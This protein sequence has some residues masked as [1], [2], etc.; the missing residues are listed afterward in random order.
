MRKKI[1]LLIGVLFL[2]SLPLILAANSVT[3]DSP[4]ANEEMVGAFILNAS[5]DTNT[6]RLENAT[7]YY[8]VTGGSW[9]LIA[10]VSN[11]TDTDFN[12]TWD[13]T[14][15]VDALNMIIAVNV[16][17]ST[18]TFNTSD[19]STGVDIDNGVPTATHSSI[20][21]ADSGKVTIDADFTLGIDADSTIGIQN[22]TFWVGSN[23]LDVTATSNACS[24]SVTTGNFSITAAGYYNYTITA[25]DANG[26]ETNTSSRRIEIVPLGGGGGKQTTVQTTTE[27]PVVT[28]TTVDTPS[29]GFFSRTIGTIGS[30]ISNFFSSI[31]NFFKNLFS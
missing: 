4:A 13:T 27:E 20:S 29:E 3:L 14:G 22:C 10:E 6:E 25:R 11:Y 9:T 18:H 15:I 31:G 7:F 23:S 2:F 12:Y 1:G 28:D 19:T 8:K 30:S 21:L 17:N 5:V 16:T 24:H 26:N